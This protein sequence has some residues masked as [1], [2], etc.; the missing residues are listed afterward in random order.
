MSAKILAIGLL[1]FLAHLLAALF[2]RTRIPDVLLLMVLGVALGPYGLAWVCTADFGQMGAVLTTIALIVI[3]FEGGVGMSI[4]TVGRALADSLALTLFTSA[5]TACAV[6]Y[7]THAFIG[8]WT[9][10]FLLGVIVSGTSSAVVIPMVT[11]L[12]MGERPRALLAMES[13]LT[14]VTCIIG[15]YALLVAFTAGVVTASDIG[16]QVL[17][18]LVMASVLGIVG[19]F[20]WLLVMGRLKNFP[21]TMSTVFAWLFIL[22]GIA[23][24]LKYSGAITA[25][26]FGVTLA[27]TPE[28]VIRGIPA[29]RKAEVGTIGDRERALFAEVVVLMKLFFFIYLGLSLRFD[30]AEPFLIGAQVVG[31]VYL[32]RIL[33]VR[34]LLPRSV[35]QRDA[36]IAGVMVPKGLAAAV[37]ATL[38]AQ[39]VGVTGGEAI[40]D[41]AYAIVGISIVVTSLL[42]PLLDAPGLRRFAPVFFSC[43]GTQE[44]NRITTTG[45]P[46]DFS[47]STAS[48]LSLVVHAVQSETAR[49]QAV[50]Q[51][52]D[53]AS[54]TPPP[55]Q[56]KP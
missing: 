26:A 50:R 12:G 41:L 37:L 11:S 45:Q 14:D 27:N 52:R 20:G 6:A 56:D 28:A 5:A 36:G 18:S 47:T 30:R 4:A 51:E 25:L 53:P 16:S 31:V 55:R 38:A 35:S 39:E 13:A 34:F 15:Y 48:A 49:I 44:R 29:L 42:V 23:E 40:K 17:A 19:G 32:M 33:L 22:Y 8:G 54:S 3:L 46:V 2:R 9:G 7:F 1:V 21:H 24:S 10:A 43:F